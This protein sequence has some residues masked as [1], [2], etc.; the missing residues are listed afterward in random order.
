M[1]VLTICIAICSNIYGTTISTASPKVGDTF[2]VNIKVASV[3]TWQLTVSFDSSKL[4]LISGSTSLVRSDDGTENV[5]VTAGTLTF[6]A[7]AAGTAYV[8]VAGNSYN[9]DEVLVP[10]GASTNIIISAA[11]VVVT[12]PPVVVTPPPATTTTTVSNNANLKKLSISVEGLN[13]SFSKS[14]TAYSV[15]VKEN[16]NNI[17]VTALAEDS[18]ATVYVSGNKNL[19]LGDNTINITVTAPDKYTKKTYTVSVVKSNNPE[20]ID[21]TL[22]TLIVENLNLGADFD[23]NITEYN[24]SEVEND[25]TKLNIVAYATNANAK[26]EV[27]GNDELKVGENTITIKVTSQNGAVTKEYFLKFIKKDGLVAA[28]NEVDIYAEANNLQDNTPSKLGEF[29]Y[30]VWMY[31]KKFWLV[32]SLLVFSLFELGQIVYL[33]R[34]L[35]RINNV[36]KEVADAKEVNS[37]FSRRGSNSIDK[38]NISDVVDNKE[39]AIDDISDELVDDSKINEI[40]EDI[41]DNFEDTKDMEED[42]K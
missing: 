2:T 14:R 37:M 10:A 42:T 6:K 20:L 19:I 30:A 36:K 38:S 32:L 25:I 24:C 8:S 4:Q 21:A 16:I 28:S 27:F 31:L 29:L 12:P 39:E 13:P 1:L 40:D 22:K 17:D 9:S 33:Y 41:S 7:T 26:I 15:G 35:R 18:K 5:S 3:S 11:P 23:T 34:K